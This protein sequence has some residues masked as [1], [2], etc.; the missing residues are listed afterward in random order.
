VI[1]LGSNAPRREVVKA[2]RKPKTKSDSAKAP[3]KED[4][5]TTERTENTEGMQGADRAVRLGGPPSL[6]GSGRLSVS[7]SFRSFR[8]QSSSTMAWATQSPSKKTN[9]LEQKDAKIA[10]K[11]KTG[12]D[13]RRFQYVFQRRRKP[14]LEARSAFFLRELRV[15]L[16]WCFFGLDQRISR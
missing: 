8:G 5:L 9:T 13:F 6:V 3:R 10:K 12:N 2:H 1:E 16:F 11:S 15:L 7:V 4:D 14:P